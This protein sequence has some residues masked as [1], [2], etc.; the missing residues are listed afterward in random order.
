MPWQKHDARVLF[1]TTALLTMQGNGRSWQQ[2][3]LPFHSYLRIIRGIP[4]NTIQ[5]SV[6]KQAH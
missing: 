4:N 5:L 2:P 3:E 1:N 6:H